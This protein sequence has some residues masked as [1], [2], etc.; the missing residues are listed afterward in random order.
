MTP[1]F[2]LTRGVASGVRRK[3]LDCLNAN[4]CEERLSAQK[5]RPV[6]I[7]LGFNVWTCCQPPRSS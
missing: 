2:S 5:K 6:A 7:A 3:P 4:A 1:N